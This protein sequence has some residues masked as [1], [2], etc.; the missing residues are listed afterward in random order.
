VTSF[1]LLA[2]VE[3]EAGNVMLC[4]PQAVPAAIPPVGTT[5]SP[6]AVAINYIFAAWTSPSELSTDT[7][8]DAGIAGFSGP[9][10]KIAIAPEPSLPCAF[11]VY[12]PDNALGTFGGGLQVVPYSFAIFPP[13]DAGP[14]PS[15]FALPAGIVAGLAVDATF[16]YWTDGATDGNVT[17]AALT[18]NSSP[19]IIAAHQT[20]PSDIAVD[21]TNA[22]WIN[23]GT[24]PGTGAVMKAP[25][26]GGGVRVVLA[27]G[28]DTPRGL[29]VLGNVVYWLT[30][31]K[32]QGAVK[33][34]HM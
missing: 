4:N 2:W 1:G 19:A 14:C 27:S 5:Q 34:I 17:Q 30:G 12:S 7:G 29:F 6:S 15:G 18:P 24:S 8:G 28:Q 3:P 9:G 13:P 26:A 32:G 20:S 11:I 22:Y 21:A 16:A 31:A 25:L 23:Q 10:G 33:M